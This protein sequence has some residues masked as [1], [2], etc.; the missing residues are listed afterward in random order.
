[1]NMAMDNFSGPLKLDTIVKNDICHCSC[2]L[3]LNTRRYNVVGDLKK[4]NIL[5]AGATFNFNKI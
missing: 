3:Y 4:L 5:A 1:M 2:S